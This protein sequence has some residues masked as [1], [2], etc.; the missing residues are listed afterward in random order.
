MGATR[1]MSGRGDACGGVVGALGQV[2][3]CGRRAISV[4]K[5]VGHGWK[6]LASVHGCLPGWEGGEVARDGR[7]IASTA[8]KVA[9]GWRHDP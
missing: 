6:G 7:A 5:A 8:A 4:G 1:A 3:S 2:E 9:R